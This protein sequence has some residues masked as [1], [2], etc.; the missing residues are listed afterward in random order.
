MTLTKPLADLRIKAV[1]MPDGYVDRVLSFAEPGTITDTHYGISRENWDMLRAEFK[2]VTKPR[3]TP[4]P[5][6]TKPAPTIEERGRALWAQL[7]I[8]YLRADP[9]LW[10]PVAERVN[11]TVF[12]LNVP[13]GECRTHWVRY[14]NDHP[15][16]LSSP[17]AAFAWSVRA[18]NAV[19]ARLG[20]DGYTNA[21]A[22]MVWLNA[23][24]PAAPA[25]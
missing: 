22:R 9:T 1:R 5:H 24:V 16:D 14:M 11:L 10:Y 23:P 19:N 21:G 12:T 6:A 15:P 7:H 25:R 2:G 4:Q 20:R 13:C 18:H 3:R 8:R 17:A